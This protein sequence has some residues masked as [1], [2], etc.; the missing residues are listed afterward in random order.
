MDEHISIVILQYGV[1]NFVV[2]ADDP[3]HLSC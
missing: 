1:G 2:I 3:R